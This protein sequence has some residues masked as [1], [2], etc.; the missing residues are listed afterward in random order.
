[1][2]GRLRLI[3]K[4]MSRGLRARHVQHCP[5]ALAHRNDTFLKIDTQL[6]RIV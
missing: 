4:P 1:M 3:D 5:H 6:R 2:L